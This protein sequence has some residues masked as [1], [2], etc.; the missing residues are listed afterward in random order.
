MLM[1]GCSDDTSTDPVT[2]PVTT[3]PNAALVLVVENREILPAYAGWAW[4]N[5]R[6]Q[7]IPLLSDFFGVPGDS[8]R[9]R[10]FDEVIDDFGE[11]WFID[12]ALTAA[13]NAYRCVV[14]LTDETAT[15]DRLLDTL[16]DLSA[17]GLT[18]DLLLN[19]HASTSTIL[20]SDRSV[21]ITEFTGSVRQRGIQ[22]R[23][24]YQTCCYASN[25]LSAWESTG[26]TAVCG[27]LN[28]NSLVIFAPLGFLTFWTNGQDF[29]SAVRQAE[30]Y[31]LIK[32]R[33]LDDRYELPSGLSMQPTATAIANSR[34]ILA[35]KD[36]LATYNSTQK[37]RPIAMR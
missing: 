16:A 37:R 32:C 7:T 2:P 29:A 31:E 19:M 35:G 1:T 18:V 30:Q 6:E 28:T 20:F 15:T 22:I 24:L 25:H 34:M 13:G 26:I 36:T 10:S 33:E 14:V 23:A 12:E 8:L 5:S 3:N 9:W 27:S 11:P 4:Q 21:P 17:E